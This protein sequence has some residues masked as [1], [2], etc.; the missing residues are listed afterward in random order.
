MSK[1]KGTLDDICATLD[2][3]YQEKKESQKVEGSA[4]EEKDNWEWLEEDGAQK[5]RP[6][7][8]D[9]LSLDLLVTPAPL[10]ATRSE[11]NQQTPLDFLW[12]FEKPAAATVEEETR[13]VDQAKEDCKGA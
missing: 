10:V 13:L 2:Q 12:H 7:E 8:W 6:A 11:S 9:I 4:A 5:R 1:Q 3:I